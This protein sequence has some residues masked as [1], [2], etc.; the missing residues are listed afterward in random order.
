MPYRYSDLDYKNIDWM[1]TDDSCATLVSVQLVKGSLRGLHPFSLELKYPLTAVAGE[2]GSGKS[3]LLAMAACAYHNRSNGYK[4]KDRTNTYYTFSDFFVQSRDEFPPQGIQICYQFLHNNWRG[5][6]PGLGRQ[7]RKKRIGGKWNDYDTRVKRNLVYFGIQRVVPHYERSAHKSYRGR[8]QIGS[9]EEEHRRRICT[10]AGRIIGKTYDEFEL[11]THSRYSLPVTSSRGVRYSGFN[12]GAGESAVFDILTALFESGR[13]TLLVI[14]EIELGLHERAQIR[15]VEE[16]KT[17]CHE[18]HCQIICSTHSHVVLATLP[19]EAR[20]F[21]ETQ[22]KRTNVT[23]GISPDLACGKLR[24]QNIGELDIFVEDGLAETILQIGLP[25]AIR[26]RVRIMRIGSFEAVLCLLSA[27]YL[28]IKDACLCVLDGDQ[29]NNH[30]KLRSRLKQRYVENKFRDSEDEINQWVEDRLIYLPSDDSPEKWLIKSSLGI[31]NKG[32]LVNEWNVNEIEV[33][34]KALEHAY[35]APAHS[36]FFEL[37]EII[38]LPEEQ[39]RA[40]LIRFVL[41][42]EPNTLQEIANSIDDLLNENV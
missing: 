36:E 14:D 27:R 19:P 28:E 6:E 11:H 18:F 3:T 7:I 26:T 38:Q 29:R 1:A 42:T 2:N 8:F 21:I 25:H 30:R 31:A 22:G 37:S 16:F 24:G 35:R 32:S 4:L 17:L 40:D 15:L 33:I 13:G 5:A 23:S 12:M 20:F 34:D 39:V 41:R 9:L 10:I